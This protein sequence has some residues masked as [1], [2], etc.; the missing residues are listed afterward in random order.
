[1]IKKSMDDI[2]CDLFYK[3]SK[4]ECISI[5]QEALKKGLFYECETC[6]NNPTVKKVFKDAPTAARDLSLRIKLNK[7]SREIADLYLRDAAKLPYPL[8]QPDEWVDT[9]YQD[10]LSPSL[11]K[12]LAVSYPEHIVKRVCMALTKFGLAIFRFSF[13]MTCNKTKIEA[14]TIREEN[15][16]GIDT[17]LAASPLNRLKMPSSL[18]AELK[19]WKRRLIQEKEQ[20]SIKPFTPSNVLDGYWVIA[21]PFKMPANRPN[22]P[23][24]KALHV[25][26]YNLLDKGKDKGKTQELTATVINDFYKTYECLYSMPKRLTAKSINDSLFKD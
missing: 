14:A 11:L 19:D 18:A 1:M 4:L 24:M 2:D 22:N 13:S 5:L 8:N 16:K 15:L 26:T 6:N 9:D 20:L 7:E 10:C 12:T 25:V 3:I 17:V 23:L 21:P